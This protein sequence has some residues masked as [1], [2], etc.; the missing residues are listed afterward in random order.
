MNS[1]VGGSGPRIALYSHDT[2]GLGHVRRNLLIARTLAAPPVNATILLITGICKAGA[3]AL[4]RGIDCLAL[5]A[6]F[7][8][9]SGRYR[10]RS[11]AMETGELSHLRGEVIK[12]GLEQ[13]EPDLL[14]V[15]NVPRGALDEM[16]PAL[17]Y[18][19]E[20]G[21]TR[22]VLGL[23]DVLDQPSVV[24]QEW[25]RRHNFKAV[26]DFYDAVWIYGDPLVY[27]MA[28]EYDFAQ[29]LWAKACY[30]GYLDPR[31]ALAGQARHR[32]GRRGADLLCV[33]GGGQDGF[34]VARNFAEAEFPG[35]TH[36]LIVTGPFMPGAERRQLARKAAARP[37]LL[38]REFVLDP[39]PMLRRAQSVVA[40]GGY[41]TVSE[42]LALEKNVL[43]VPR[44]QPRMEQLIRARRLKAL[45]LVDYIPHEKLSADAISRW[46]R[47]PGRPAS[48]REAIDF[49]GLE[50]VVDQV[51]ILVGDSPRRE[52][53]GAE[54]R[55][56]IAAE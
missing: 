33:V 6:Y 4:P 18:L 17:T 1:G 16:I 7:K 9:E 22:C 34:N 39:A 21:R 55:F 13:F 23:R 41:N 51:G 28:A 54:A 52:V 40:M 49:N 27:D 5:P 25:H 19:A 36:G 26:R 50:R 48:A 14:I 10:S 44:T 31:G 2:M 29:E 24:Q 53:S 46:L 43:L 32:R 20:Q 47:Q 8:E 3:F 56:H 12:T 15:D 42:I 37:E 38:V 45:G 11:L 30:T 35:Q